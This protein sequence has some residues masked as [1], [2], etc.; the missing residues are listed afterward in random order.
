MSM[1]LYIILLCTINLSLDF[2][3]FFFLSNMA[4]P[5]Q[6]K[7]LTRG[8][9]RWRH[10]RSTMLL[11]RPE[12]NRVSLRDA[13][14]LCVAV[15]S[16][17]SV[18]VTQLLFSLANAYAVTLIYKEKE[19]SRGTRGQISSPLRIGPSTLAFLAQIRVTRTS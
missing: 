11:H 16:W 8:H 4:I 12:E 5:T 14:R 2:M 15:A 19:A 13:L 7:V 9:L 10:H 6:L 3:V 18:A 1:C 17:T